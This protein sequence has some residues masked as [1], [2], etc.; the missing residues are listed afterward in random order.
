MTE[1]REFQ[2]RTEEIEQLMK[3]LE[4]TAEPAVH[5]AALEL[6][7]TIME[8]HGAA[9]GRILHV[10]SLEPNAER[11]CRELIKDELVS[12]VLL[13]HNLHP[14]DIHTRVSRALENVRPYLQSHGGDVQ[15]VDVQDGVLRVR[16]QGSCGSCGSSAQT[17]KTAVE[18]AVVNAAPDVTEIIAEPGTEPNTAPINGSQ[19]VVLG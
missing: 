16:L 18:Q 17:L 10:L 6:M 5:A 2:A 11:L 1:K 15:L 4:E 12:G 14:E 7:Q 9:V 3:I 13:L 8:L 19:L